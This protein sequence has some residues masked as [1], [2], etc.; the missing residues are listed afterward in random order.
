MAEF[1]GAAQAFDLSVSVLY[2]LRAIGSFLLIFIIPGLVWTLVIFKKLHMVAR[3]VL[4]FGLSVAIVTLIVFVPSIAMG[5]PITATNT[6]VS[7]AVVTGI[8]LLLYALRKLQESRA[9][10]Q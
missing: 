1:S 2:Y 6:L 4:S 9:R 3:I 10:N 7:I 8:A 5:M